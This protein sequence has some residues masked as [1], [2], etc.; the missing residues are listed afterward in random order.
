MVEAGHLP[1]HQGPRWQPQL[2]ERRGVLQGA[3][4]SHKHR[5][6][7]GPSITPHPL[8]ASSREASPQLGH[9]QAGQGTRCW[10]RQGGRPSRKEKPNSRSQAR[11]W[12]ATHGRNPT[13]GHSRLG[14]ASHPSL[15]GQGGDREWENDG[16]WDVGVSRHQR[17]E[18]SKPEPRQHPGTP[19]RPLRPGCLLAPRACLPAD[20]EPAIWATSCHTKAGWCRPP[21]QCTETDRR[22]ALPRHNRMDAQG[23]GARSPLQSQTVAGEGER[24]GW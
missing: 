22:Q 1:P 3:Q 23:R 16:K 12:P 4:G 11:G 2:G 6:A 13:A 19:I 24:Q 20:R 15:G 8:L 7:W 10:E 17:S 5:Q 14:A 18:A 21:Q 9:T